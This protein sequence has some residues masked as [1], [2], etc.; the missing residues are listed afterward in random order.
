[1]TTEVDVG[2]M[3]AEGEPSHQYPSHFVAV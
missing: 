2:G 3:A 1:M